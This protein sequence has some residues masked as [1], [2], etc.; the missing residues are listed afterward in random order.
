M[1][2]SLNLS[3]KVSKLDSSIVEQQLDQFTKWEEGA[4]MTQMN[5]IPVEDLPDF[6]DHLLDVHLDSGIYI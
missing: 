5:Q 1:Y 6:L 3:S 4:E 2:N